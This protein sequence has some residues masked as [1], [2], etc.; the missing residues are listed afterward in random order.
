MKSFVSKVSCIA[1]SIIL[2][3]VFCFSGAVFAEE[4]QSLTDEMAKAATSI[5]ISPVS[6]VLQLEPDKVYED[7]FDVANNGDDNMKFEVYASPYS[8][9]FSEEVKT[10]FY[11]FLKTNPF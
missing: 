11:R 3:S 7:S 9:T 10:L 2:G 8:Y 4:E 6:K 1:V 5:S